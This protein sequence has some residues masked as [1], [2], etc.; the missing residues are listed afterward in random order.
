MPFASVQGEVWTED[1]EEG[2]GEGEDGDGK[3]KKKRED[4]PPQFTQVELQR[5]EVLDVVAV[6]SVNVKPKNKLNVTIVNAESARVEVQ[7]IQASG[8][9]TTHVILVRARGGWQ[10]RAW[11]PQPEHNA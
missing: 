4:G 2:D 9:R 8:N 3:K 5:P 6:Q 11:L 7:V 1:E 10:C